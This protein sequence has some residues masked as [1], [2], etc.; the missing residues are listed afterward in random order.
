VIQA[1][2]SVAMV[3]TQV[4]SVAKEATF[5]NHYLYSDSMNKQLVTLKALVAGNASIEYISKTR[6][7]RT[8]GDT[9]V[10]GHQ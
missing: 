4:K 9:T 10:V 5:I 8:P 3:L 6:I 7:R 1:V 2:K